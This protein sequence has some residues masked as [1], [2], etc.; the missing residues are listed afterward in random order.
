ML[1]VRRVDGCRFDQ[2]DG[3]GVTRLLDLHP[4]D[5]NRGQVLGGRALEVLASA[6]PRQL[7]RLL[8]E[9]LVLDQP[10]RR[11]GDDTANHQGVEAAAHVVLR[12]HG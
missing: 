9:P 7:E 12:E 8:R 1:D 10:P 5:E 3:D 2:R 11:P 6:Y 4:R